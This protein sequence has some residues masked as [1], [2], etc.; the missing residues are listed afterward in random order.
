M[1]T[2]WEYLN[3]HQPRKP[4]PVMS[5]ADYA[6]KLIQKSE[7][8][9]SRGRLGSLVKLDTETLNSLLN[10]FVRG[11]QAKVFRQGDFVVYRAG[12]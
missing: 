5:Q 12:Y 2:F 4:G 3:H 1:K 10:A 7:G 9:I 11:G 8:G 6:L